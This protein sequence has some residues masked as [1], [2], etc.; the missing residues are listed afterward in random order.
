VLARASSVV[1]CIVFLYVKIFVIFIKQA[2]L[3]G[4]SAQTM[5]YMPMHIAELI[6]CIIFL[7]MKIFACFIKQAC[8]FAIISIL[9]GGVD[10]SILWLSF[11][12]QI[13]K[14]EK[15]VFFFR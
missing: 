2:C 14:I 1:D 10:D 4:A 6:A 7:F 8:L 5:P 3:L 13:N 12:Q 15:N 11:A 9:G